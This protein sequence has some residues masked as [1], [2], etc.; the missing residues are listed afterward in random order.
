MGSPKKRPRDGEQDIWVYCKLLT[1]NV[2][3]RPA[4]QKRVPATVG[5]ERVA[6]TGREHKDY[7]LTKGAVPVTASIPR[8]SSSRGGALCSFKM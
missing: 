2:Q 3:W 5:G 8:N 4:G 7:M 6:Y 1:G